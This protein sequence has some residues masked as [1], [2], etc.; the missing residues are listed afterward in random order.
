M[1]RRL[2]QKLADPDVWCWVL[3]GSLVVTIVIFDF[4]LDVLKFR[5]L[6]WYTHRGN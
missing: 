4:Y 6:E 3:I 1:T 2:K 5:F